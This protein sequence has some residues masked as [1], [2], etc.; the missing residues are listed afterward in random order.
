[1]PNRVLLFCLLGLVLIAA[2]ML[3][4]APEEVTWALSL[5]DQNDLSRRGLCCR[6]LRVAAD[7]GL[8]AHHSNNINRRPQRVTHLDAHQPT[9]VGKA[10]HRVRAANQTPWAHAAAAGRDF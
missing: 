2:I 1:M 8:R 4:I 7:I 5:I 10:L 9:A 3:L 6:A